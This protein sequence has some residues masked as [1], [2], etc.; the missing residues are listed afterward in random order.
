MRLAVATVMFSLLVTVLGT[1]LMLAVRYNDDVAGAHR[2]LD[3]I[4]RSY[5]PS[6][7]TSLWLVDQDRVDLQLDELAKIPGVAEVRLRSEG[8]ELDR[9]HAVHDP[10]L[11]RSFPLS[12]N[13]AGHFDLGTLQV[14]FGRAPVIAKL[15][16]RSVGIALATL[17][18]L[19]ATSLSVLLLVRLWV[20]RHL[21][22][23]ARYAR[24]V[25]FEQLQIPLDLRRRRR[26]SSDEFDEVVASFNRMRERFL[27]ELAVR[28]RHETEL[29]NHRDRLESLVSARTATLEAQTLQLEQQKR[30]LQRLA[31]TDSLTGVLSRRC[32]LELV[33]AEML[34]SRRQQQPLSV[35]ML[36]VD[37][38]K[39]VNDG[40]GHAGGD[41]MLTVVADTC[42]G[43]LREV[44]AI[45]RIGGEEF[46]IL[47]PQADAEGAWLVAERLRV[48]VA[49]ARVVLDDGT[50]IS[51]T[52]SIGIGELQGTQDGPE[53]L[54]ARADRALYEAKRA[55]RNQVQG[56]R[57]AGSHDDPSGS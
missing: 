51:C 57:D 16:D 13:E 35:L 43:M 12:Y 52:V 5:V 39:Q 24:Y 23:L 6:L 15:E 29:E 27:G 28:A 9:G 32:Y 2:R 50:S 31:N 3:E 53:T 37:H 47:L 21:E 38:F 25:T 4:G 42:K 48:A 10:L 30:D 18:T 33:S 49:G 45:G 56:P 22:A 20:T 26:R 19:L 7:S 14:A 1:V 8:V 40:H 41:R 44:D 55:G 11:L 46:S 54:I 17:V 36:D 34:R